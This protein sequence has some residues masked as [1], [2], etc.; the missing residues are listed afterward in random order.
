MSRFTFRPPRH[1]GYNR[2]MNEKRHAAWPWIIFAVLTISIV[3]LIFNNKGED[4]TISEIRTQLD[5]L[6]KKVE[7][8][9][10]LELKKAE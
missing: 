8:L 10:S 4:K 5:D 7:R 2:G 3:A 6:A 9:E 1:A